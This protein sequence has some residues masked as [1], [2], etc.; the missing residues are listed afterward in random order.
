MSRSASSCVIDSRLAVVTSSCH[1]DLAMEQSA[2]VDVRDG[3]PVLEIDV[4]AFS[5][6]GGSLVVAIRPYNPEGVQFIDDVEARE[7]RTAGA[8]IRERK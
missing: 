8:S 1:G 4:R 3:Q 5:A 2:Y 7:A 6:A